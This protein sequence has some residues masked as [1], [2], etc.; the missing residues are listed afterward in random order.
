MG[1]SILQVAQCQNRSIYSNRLYFLFSALC[2]FCSNDVGFLFS[3]LASGG[4]QE[5]ESP[6]AK[7]VL[8]IT[9]RN[10]LNVINNLL[11]KKGS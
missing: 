8:K 2:Y 1:L 6:T 11:I 9:E 5:Q 3:C 7:R 4:W 10:I